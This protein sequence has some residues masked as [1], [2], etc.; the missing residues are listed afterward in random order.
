MTAQTEGRFKP[1]TPSERARALVLG[2][3]L[4]VKQAEWLGQDV[5]EN[6]KQM[7]AKPIPANQP[8]S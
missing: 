7:A 5:D 3:R 4:L 8:A 2:A 6:V 1:Y